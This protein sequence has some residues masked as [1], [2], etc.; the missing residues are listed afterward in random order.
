MGEGVEMYTAHGD[1]RICAWTPSTSNE[2]EDEEVEVEVDAKKPS[3]FQTPLKRGQNVDATIAAMDEAERR[4]KRK[5]DLIGDLV[6]G[7]TRRPIPF[8]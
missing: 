7:L 1:G 3:S 5:R 8:S 6:E 2:D 4:R